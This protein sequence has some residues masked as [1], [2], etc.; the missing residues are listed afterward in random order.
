ML[1]SCCIELAYARAASSV[2]DSVKA[3]ICV[4]QT[5][6]LP[7]IH[8]NKLGKSLYTFMYSPRLENIPNTKYLRPAI[9]KNFG[10]EVIRVAYRENELGLCS[11]I[12]VQLMLYLVAGITVCCHATPNLVAA[13][14][15]SPTQLVAFIPASKNSNNRQS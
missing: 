3:R 8:T 12:P 5:L 7:N 15:L 11:N 10:S 14:Y 2:V 9:L 1:H 6:L 13:A 4:C